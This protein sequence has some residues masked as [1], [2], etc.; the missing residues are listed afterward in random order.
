MDNAFKKIKKK[1]KSIP[2]KNKNNNVKICEND[3]R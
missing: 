2:C 1:D 3:A